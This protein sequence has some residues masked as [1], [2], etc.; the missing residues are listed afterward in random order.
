MMW[1]SLSFK[2][3]PFASALKLMFILYFHYCILCTWLSCNKLFSTVICG[4]PGSIPFYGVL[5]L[6]KQILPFR[7][8]TVLELLT[9][10]CFLLVIHNAMVSHFSQ[11][12]PYCILTLLFVCSKY[13]V[14]HYYHSIL[15]PDILWKFCELKMRPIFFW[16]WHEFPKFFGFFLNLKFRNVVFSSAFSSGGA[17]F[18]FE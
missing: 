5:R 10:V 7:I 15:P 16:Q 17:K 4:T 18:L 3:L 6:I 14:W 11:C 12:Y 13:D 9:A 2:M 8:R 1:C